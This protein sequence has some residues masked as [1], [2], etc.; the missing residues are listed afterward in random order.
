MVVKGHR[1][2][3]GPVNVITYQKN[4]EAAAPGQCTQAEEGES[5]RRPPIAEEA[6]WEDLELLVEFG[7]KLEEPP[8]DNLNVDFRIIGAV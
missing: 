4:E 6:D 3:D 8:I 5:G 2:E 7:R 1:P